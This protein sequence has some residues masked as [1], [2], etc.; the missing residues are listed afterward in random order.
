MSE[1]VVDLKQL[2]EML[3]HFDTLHIVYHDKMENFDSFGSLS[4]DIT[5]CIP[6]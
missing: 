2:R 6:R 5:Y 1:T 4:K 3:H